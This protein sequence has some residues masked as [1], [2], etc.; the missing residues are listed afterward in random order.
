M[1]Q[2]LIR[3]SLSIGL[4]IVVGIPSFLF[5]Q[6][7][8]TLFGFEV[9]GIVGYSVVAILATLIFV[10]LC[11]LVVSAILGFMSALKR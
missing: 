3:F 10:G 6:Y 2:L 5:A 1:R 9:A 7:L 4:L 11:S 8:L